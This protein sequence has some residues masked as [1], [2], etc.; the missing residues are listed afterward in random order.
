MEFRPVIYCQRIF[1]KIFKLTICIL[2]QVKV[3]NRIHTLCIV[4]C[5]PNTRY[6]SSKRTGRIIIR[7]R[8]GCRLP[9]KRLQEISEY[10][11]PCFQFRYSI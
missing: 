9:D 4:P 1:G 11:L 6:Q 5:P 3:N 7:P 10:L 8:R 2:Q